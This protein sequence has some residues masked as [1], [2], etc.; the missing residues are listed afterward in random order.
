[1]ATEFLRTLSPEEFKA[2]LGVSSIQVIE[3]PI[4]KTKLVQAEG[5]IV[6]FV[7][8]KG[9]DRS[10]AAVSQ[11]LNTETDEAYWVLHTRGESQADV[12]DTFQLGVSFEGGETHLQSL[13][14]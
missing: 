1:M 2:H 4:A 6:A 5:N 7:S 13:N 12:L 3:T 11:L 14:Y 9:Y 8:T 10:R